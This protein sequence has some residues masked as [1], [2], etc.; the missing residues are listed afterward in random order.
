MSQ[1]K[2]LTPKQELFTVEYLRDRNA[3]RAAIAAGYSARTAQQQGSR[4]LRNVLVRR[5][6]DARTEAIHEEVKIDKEELFRA[7]LRILRFDPRRL[8]DRKGNRIP[9]HKLP[10][11]VA[12]ALEGVKVFEEFEG[13]GENRFKIGETRDLAWTKKTEAIRLLGQ[14]LGL[15]KEHV[16][17]EGE[18][19]VSDTLRKAR[20]RGETVVTEAQEPPGA[21]A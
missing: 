11:E 7:L 5:R 4:L 16:K 1:K 19:T 8:Y 6:I 3:T 13:K 10:D 21:G 15:F 2:R 12:L 9:L 14:H 17:V 18:V 20:E